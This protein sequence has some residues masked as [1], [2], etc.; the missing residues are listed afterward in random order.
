MEEQKNIKEKMKRL[1]D[2]FES[3]DKKIVKLC[4]RIRK[5]EKKWQEI[6][7]RLHQ[8]LVNNGKAI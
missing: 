8:C 6:D 1:Q 2:K 7:E 3:N 4:K 5:E